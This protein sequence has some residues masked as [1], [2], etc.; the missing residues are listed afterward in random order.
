[1]QSKTPLF[2]IQDTYNT[3]Q[4]P[5]SNFQ[6]I[7]PIAAVSL[8]A[9]VQVLLKKGIL[10]E[11]ELIEKEQ[12]L[13][14]QESEPVVQM[15][16]DEAPQDLNDHSDTVPADPDTESSSAAEHEAFPEWKR[17]VEASPVP[18][19]VVSTE[20][21]RVQKP[22]RFRRLRKWMARRKWRRRLGS[23]LFGWKWRKKGKDGQFEHFP[24]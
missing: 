22:V 1:M 15:D 19:M 10:T 23:A 11:E 21:R 12:Q 16:V 20:S 18:Q 9:V 7:R 14:Q 3:N 4:S 17:V 5:N 13:R 24:H 2:R 6:P 8:Q